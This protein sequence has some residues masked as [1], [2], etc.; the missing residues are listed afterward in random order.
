VLGKI[1]TFF[2]CIFII[3]GCSQ[4]QKQLITVEDLHK[5]LSPIDSDVYAGYNPKPN[6]FY[7]GNHYLQRNIKLDQEKKRF[8]TTTLFDKKANMNWVGSSSD[9]FRFRI[10]KVVF[11]GKSGNLKYKSYD[12]YSYSQIKELVVFFEYKPEEHEIFELSVHYQIHSNIPVI[13]KWLEFY[14]LTDRTFSVE[15]L[16][17]ESIQLSTELIKFCNFQLEELQTVKNNEPLIIAFLQSIHG[18]LILSSN[19]PG[20]LKKYHIKDRKI[21]LGMQTN[22]SH[23][24]TDIKVPSGEKK[25]S[26]Q[27][28]IMPFHQ[29]ETEHTQQMNKI[30]QSTWLNFVRLYLKIA[31]HF[32]DNTY[33]QLNKEISTVTFINMGERIPDNSGNLICVDWNIG[34]TELG[35][36]IEMSK[37][38]HEKQK[39]FGVRVRLNEVDAEFEIQDKWIFQKHNGEKWK[40]STKEGVVKK[41]CCLA[42]EYL[43]YLTEYLSFLAEQV[44]LDYIIFDGLLFGPDENNIGCTSFLHEHS[45]PEDSIMLIYQNIFKI[46]EQLHTYYPNLSIAI[47]PEAYAIDVP[48]YAL[49]PYIEQFLLEPQKSKIKLEQITKFFPQESLMLELNTH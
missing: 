8:T 15:C 33:T 22:S 21:A 27:V 25:A 9:E 3:V 10:G 2:I 20:A 7:I 1:V 47:T 16:N 39:K 12:I 42:S 34:E 5:S 30:W 48:D 18:G 38:I 35:D 45:T 36:L 24:K 40:S 13:I 6:G 17:I 23:W 29:E 28:F 32:R 41:H 19:I 31:S 14:N 26:Y 11:T 4:T 49:L 43:F 44:N 46:A 37:N